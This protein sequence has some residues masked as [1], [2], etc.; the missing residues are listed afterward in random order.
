MD[1]ALPN[2]AMA[3]DPEIEPGQPMSEEYLLRMAALGRG[4]NPDVAAE[5]L[6]PSALPEGG[7]PE[8]LNAETGEY[9][10]KAHA[11]A[12]TKAPVEEKKAAPVALKSDAEVGEYLSK[13]AL[14][15]NVLNST[16]MAK[17]DIDPEHYTALEGLGLP[18]A[19]IQEHVKLARA[20]MEAHTADAVKHAGGDDAAQSMLSW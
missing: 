3:G 6:K 1:E 16:I 2:L 4:E 10:W 17:G 5:H 14:D 18:K 15:P 7:L 12:G 8:F 11:L 9:D 20:S 19:L 13:A